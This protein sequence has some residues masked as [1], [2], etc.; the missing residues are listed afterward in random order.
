M[1][2]SSMSS[3]IWEAVCTTERWNSV[4]A[5]LQRENCPD[6]DLQGGFAGQRVEQLSQQQS[7]YDRQPQRAR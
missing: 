1:E 2:P 5:D 3:D 6:A 4:D 7:G